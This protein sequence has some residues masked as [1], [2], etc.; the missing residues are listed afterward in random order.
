MCN[1]GLSWSFFYIVY[2]ILYSRPFYLCVTVR[3]DFHSA[4]S[5]TL[6]GISVFFVWLVTSKV[7]MVVMSC[8][9]SGLSVAGWNAL[10]VISM[11]QYPTH[12]RYSRSCHFRSCWHCFIV[13]KC[14]SSWRKSCTRPR[15]TNSGIGESKAMT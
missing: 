5:M 10:D 12:L 3:V 15:F 14:L 6:S 2:R 8:I 7:E 11:E 13:I 9:F 4:L 1:Q